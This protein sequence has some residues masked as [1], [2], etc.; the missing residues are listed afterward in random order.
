MARDWLMADPTDLYVPEEELWRPAQDDL[1]DPDEESRKRNWLTAD[2]DPKDS[3]WI[4][5]DQQPEETLVA[6]EDMKLSYQN[7]DA[8]MMLIYGQRGTGKSWLGAEL[9]NIFITVSRQQGHDQKVFS[10]IELDFADEIGWDMYQRIAD[11]KATHYRNGFFFWDEVGEVMAA[12]RAMSK[13]VLQNEA[14]IVMLRKQKIDV[15]ATTQWPHMLTNA[16]NVQC[17]FF[18]KPK[19]V[20]L[21][22]TVSA[23]GRPTK[24]YMKANI[25]VQAWN[26]NGSM[27]N[28]PLF[29][30]RITELPAPQWS[31]TLYGVENVRDFYRTEEI[32]TNVH[33][34]F[35]KEA[36]AAQK[37]MDES[38][39]TLAKTV[40][41]GADEI[42]IELFMERVMPYIESVAENDTDNI[43]EVY[44]K[45]IAEQVGFETTSQGTILRGGW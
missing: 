20:E 33:T 4:V 9:C 31:F 19:L 34:D 1:Y 22:K 27:T 8:R 41:M 13:I 28:R 43:D 42:S 30:Y 32:V 7:S 40:F 38:R 15:I 44:A 10:N 45:R 26:F 39:K 17:D 36:I 24:R 6:V 21:F 29:K 12:K 35:G 18:V 11:P 14:S 2:Q 37:K 23:P 5:G 16:F 3:R 25:H